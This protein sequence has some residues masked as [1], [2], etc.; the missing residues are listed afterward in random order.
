MRHASD[1]A[2]HNEPA[3]LRGKCDCRRLCSRC[4]EVKPREQYAK[5]QRWC[6]E[7]QRASRKK[8]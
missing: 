5:G 2:R 3:L 4:L 7:C 6:K 8:R 1:C